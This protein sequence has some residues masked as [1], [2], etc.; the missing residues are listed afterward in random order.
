MKNTVVGAAHV[1]Q[2]IQKQTN[3]ITPRNPDRA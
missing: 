1:L 2:N 3:K